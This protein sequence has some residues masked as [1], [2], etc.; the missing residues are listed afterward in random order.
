MT[1]HPWVALYPHTLQG[2]DQARTQ[3]SGTWDPSPANVGCKP[4]QGATP[5]PCL[6]QHPHSH[7]TVI[8]HVRVLLVGNSTGST[9]L[10]GGCHSCAASM[11]SG[12]TLACCPCPGQRQPDAPACISCEHMQRKAWP[13]PAPSY[14]TLQQHANP[15]CLLIP[16]PGC[17]LGSYRYSNLKS[18]PLSLLAAPSQRPSHMQL[19]VATHLGPVTVQS[20][21]NTPGRPT[22][23]SMSKG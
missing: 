20:P 17:V 3:G 12:T 21:M 22:T 13:R 18:P 14:T 1:T 4:A 16:N 10:C 23:H 2:M 8:P 5:A 19:A 9:Q 11:F 6:L 7:T 15:G